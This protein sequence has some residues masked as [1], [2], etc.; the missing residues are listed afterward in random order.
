LLGASHDDADGL[1]TVGNA[2]GGPGSTGGGGTLTSWTLFKSFIG[3]VSLLC[4]GGGGMLVKVGGF[5]GAFRVG[6]FLLKLNSAST[7][8]D[9]KFQRCVLLRRCFNGFASTTTFLCCC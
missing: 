3:V 7:T 9:N 2:G 5:A 1:E 8:L 6:V 4:V